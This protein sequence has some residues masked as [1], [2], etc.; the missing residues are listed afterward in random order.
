VRPT[1]V[2]NPTADEP[3]ARRARAL[4]DEGLSTIDALQAALREAGYPRTVVRAR[5]LSSEP[6]QV[7]YVYREGA[8]VP[9]SE[10]RDG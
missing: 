10:P 9:S 2:V 1:L 3:F 4:V 6:A 7:W 5:E 8:W